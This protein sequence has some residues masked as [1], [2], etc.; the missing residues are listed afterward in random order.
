[1][2]KVPI[3]LLLT[4]SIFKQMA[5]VSQ[6][7]VEHGDFKGILTENFRL[8]Q[9][10]FV[11]KGYGGVGGVLGEGVEGWVNLLKR[12]I[13]NENLFSDNVE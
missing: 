2:P 4:I 5:Q 10:I 6:T 9:Q 11:V 1:M 7:E 12:N 13:C 3:N 8:V